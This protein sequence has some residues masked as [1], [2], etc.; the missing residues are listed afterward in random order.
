LSLTVETGTHTGS[1]RGLDVPV[2][3]GNTCSAHAKKGGS[4]SETVSIPESTHEVN[5]DDEAGG[6]GAVNGQVGGCTSKVEG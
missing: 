4:I 2:P 5:D 3:R 1:Y 6:D